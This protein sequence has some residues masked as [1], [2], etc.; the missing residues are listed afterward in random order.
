MAKQTS[1][2]MKRV[3]EVLGVTV[4]VIV[5]CLVMC[6]CTPAAM[7][8]TFNDGM[9]HTVGS[10]VVINDNIYVYNGTTLEFNGI[11][12]MDIFIYDNSHLYIDSEGQTMNIRAYDNSTIEAGGS[13]IADVWVY[14]NSTLIYNSGDIKSL[15]ASDHSKV[16]YNSYVDYGVYLSGNA[17]LSGDGG[18]YEI[19][20]SGHTTIFGNSPFLFA[21]MSGATI[22]GMTLTDGMAA[23]NV[24]IFGGYYG[25]FSEGFFGDATIYGKNFNVPFGTYTGSDLTSE[26]IGTLSY[27][28]IIDILPIN[29]HGTLTLVKAPEPTTVLLLGSG[30]LGLWGARKKFKR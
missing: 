6:L 14:D 7:E 23:S 25:P 20:A 10:D 2:S 28:G 16:I 26:L 9:V 12:T 30:L 18:G 15:F 19:F 13:Y 17:T 11:A 27:G 21:E 29:L 22:F 3:L 24:R 1:I 4:I 5:M 8:L